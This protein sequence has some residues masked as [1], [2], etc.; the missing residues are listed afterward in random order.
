MSVQ[1]TGEQLNQSISEIGKIPDAEYTMVRRFCD[2]ESLEFLREADDICT[3]CLMFHANG[4][5]PEDEVAS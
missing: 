2:R 1:I 4:D 3:D 5:L